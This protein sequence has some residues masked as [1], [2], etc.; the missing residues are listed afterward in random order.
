MT[1][2][3]STM[4]DT[5]D[6]MRDALDEMYPDADALSGEL[7]SWI[8]HAQDHLLEAGAGIERALR[9]LRDGNFE[10]T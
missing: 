2:Q 8:F 7:S 6:S 3:L 5:I 9:L 1:S 10:E 4:L